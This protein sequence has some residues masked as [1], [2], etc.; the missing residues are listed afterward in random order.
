[1]RYTQIDGS[2]HNLRH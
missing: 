1:M 2:L